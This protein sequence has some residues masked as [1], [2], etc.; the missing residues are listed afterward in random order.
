MACTFCAASEIES[1]ILKKPQKEILDVI[2]R[3][4][5]NPLI[6]TGGE[7]LMMPPEYYY[8]FL[9]KYPEINIDMTSNLKDFYLNPEKWEKLFKHKNVSICT[10]FN[11]GNTRKWSKNEVYSKDKFVKVMNLFKNRIGYMP[12]FIAVIDKD[13]ED[14][15]LDTVLLAKD[16]GTTCRINNALK[17]GRQDKYYPRYKI[18]KKWLNIIDAGLEEYE[19][20][21][22][23]RSI[24]RCPINSNGLCTFSIRCI[25][26]DNNGK[27]HYSNCEDKVNLG[28]NDLSIEDDELSVKPIKYNDLISMECLSCELYSICNSCE[29]NREQIK[30]YAPEHCEHMS[31]LKDRIIEAG[32]KL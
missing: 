27:I 15:V 32:W 6:F 28:Y 20:N 26:I 19:I 4:N 25:Y 3:L 8:Y 13:N 2:D 17:I 14:T 21:C 7:P 16:L 9:E 1:P 22:R 29:S 18:F 11:F 31:K 30:R 24:G 23:D 10:S 5:P 12:P